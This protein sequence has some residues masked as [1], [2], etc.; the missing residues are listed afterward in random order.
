MVEFYQAYSTYEDLM[1]MTE[2]MFRTIAM[3]VNSSL[4]IQYQGET[5]DFRGVD[6]QGDIS[7]TSN[8]DLS[9]NGKWRRISMIESL[10]SIGGVD[11]QIIG[12]S[13]KLLQFADE[14]GIKITKKERYGKIL[15]KLFDT[16]VEC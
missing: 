1:D 7:S 12:N 13:E 11:P 9:N 14:K 8:A 6:S 4:Q 15:T 2:E 5:I 10:S 16:L 3:E